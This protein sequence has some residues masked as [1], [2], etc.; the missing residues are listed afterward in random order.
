MPIKIKSIT[1]ANDEIVLCTLK[2]NLNCYFI[3]PISKFQKF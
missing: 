3:K 1:T 2:T